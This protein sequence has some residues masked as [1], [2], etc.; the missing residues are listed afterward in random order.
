VI[1]SNTA[2]GD[3]VAQNRP[4]RRPKGSPLMM[5]FVSP[6]KQ[7]KGKF[8]GYGIIP[9]DPLQ[10]TRSKHYVKRSVITIYISSVENLGSYSRK[11]LAAGQ[12]SRLT[13][14]TAWP[15]GQ[16]VDSHTK[17]R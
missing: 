10:Y 13:P 12:E 17:S 15:L 5:S 1:Y 14:D 7:H 8:S 2:A 3:D 9:L 4:E 6:S 11:P 16:S